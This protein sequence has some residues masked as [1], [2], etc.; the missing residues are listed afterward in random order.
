MILKRK[1]IILTLFILALVI[2]NHVL[3]G[4]NPIQCDKV[5]SGNSVATNIQIFNSPIAGFKQMMNAPAESWKPYKWS[6]I[7]NQKIDTWLRLEFDNT[8]GQQAQKFVLGNNQFQ[9]IDYYIINADSS[10][11]IK[12]GGSFCDHRKMDLVFGANSWFEINVPAHQT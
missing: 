10:I 9:Y 11:Q 12:A 2:S 5:N 6:D 8:K 1:F 3:L 4:Q 7:P